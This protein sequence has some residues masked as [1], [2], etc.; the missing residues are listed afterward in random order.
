MR[1]PHRYDRNQNTISKE[2]CIQLQKS[3]VLVVGCGGLG[4]HIIEH[5]ARLGVGRITALDYDVFDETNLNRQLLSTEALIGKPKAEAAVAR[6]KEVNSE[7]EVNGRVCCIRKDNAEEIVKGHDL[8]IDA[9]DNIG[10]RFALEEACQ[11]LEIPMVHGAIG[12][13]YG[14]V[15]V[16]MPGQPLLEKIYGTEEDGGLEEELGNPSF[17]PAVIAGIQVAEGVKV[18]L[19]KELTLKGK[20]LTVDLQTLEFDVLDID[21]M[22]EEE[23]R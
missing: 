8:V 18:L 21:S 13:W 16:I 1:F 17:T 4:G 9:L 20:I 11:A 10:S 5:L 23:Q 15:A 14:Q 2:E 7:V 12:G 6:M 3:N 19:K 22:E